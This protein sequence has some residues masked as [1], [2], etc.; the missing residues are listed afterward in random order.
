M[1]GRLTKAGD[2]RKGGQD[3][4][5]IGS[6]AFFV[7][8]GVPC[9]LQGAAARLYWRG[10]GP[11]LQFLPTPARAGAALVT[12][13]MNGERALIAL[14]DGGNLVGIAG[15]RGAAGGF[16]TPGIGDFRATFGPVRG[17]LRYLSSHLHRGGAETRDLILDGVAVRPPWRERGIARALV[18]A[19]MDE[20]RRLGH[21]ALRVEVEAR[22]IAALATWTALGFQPLD[23]QNL[24]WPWRARAHVL[25]LPV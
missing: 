14:S 1:A 8:R 25:R 24:G 5:A 3:L 7:H 10:F 15:L 22:N 18:L 9:H 16:L 6:S 2:R 23:R 20:A 19:A 21:P 13:T 11:A 4:N 17:L 12:A